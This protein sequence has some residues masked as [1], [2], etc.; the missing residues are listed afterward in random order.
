MYIEFLMTCICRVYSCLLLWNTICSNKLT[1]PSPLTHLEEPFHKA[2]IEKWRWWRQREETK[3][4]LSYIK[5]AIWKDLYYSVWC[6]PFWRVLERVPQKKTLKWELVW[7]GFVKKI[8]HR[9]TNEVGQARQGRE[10]SQE[11]IK[12][13]QNLSL[14]LILQESFEG[15]F[16]KESFNCI[17]ELSNLK[18]ASWTS[19]LLH[20]HWLRSILPGM[21]CDV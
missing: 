19:T 3:E 1:F 14:S 10:R 12:F 21:V 5:I 7:K 8:I 11:G 6:I 2:N 16:L 18:K 20:H 13:S 15:N 17:S 4:T 9:R